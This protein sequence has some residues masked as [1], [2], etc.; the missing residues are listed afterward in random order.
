[1]IPE[2]TGSGRKWSD[3]KIE[4]EVQGGLQIVQLKFPHFLI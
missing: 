3:W 4:N 1:M 2:G